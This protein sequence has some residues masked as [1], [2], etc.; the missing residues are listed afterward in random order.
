MGI[1]NKDIVLGQEVRIRWPHLL[2]FPLAWVTGILSLQM[3]GT[4]LPDSFAFLSSCG[5]ALLGTILIWLFFLRGLDRSI[6]LP[7]ILSLFILKAIFVYYIWT[8]NV[9][10]PMGGGNLKVAQLPYF[11]ETLFFWAQMNK[12]VQYW[13][14]N[15]FT[16]FLPFRHV[17]YEHPEA[18]CLV[19]MPFAALPTYSEVL[20][21][22]NMFYTTVAGAAIYAIGTLEGFSRRICKLAFYL[23]L[24]Q[25]FGWYVWAPLKRDTQCQMCFG[26]FVLA[27]LLCRKRITLLILVSVL[28]CYVL[29]LYRTVYGPILICTAIYAYIS[30]DGRV[31]EKVVR[32]FFVVFIT[33]TLLFCLTPR[34]Y[35]DRVVN[36]VKHLITFYGVGNAEVAR[37]KGYQPRLMRHDSWIAS[38]PDRVVFGLVSPFPWI[39]VPNSKNAFEYSAAV[40]D[41][42][43]TALMFVCFAAIA[44]FGLHDLMKG[45]FPPV[46]I[47]FAMGIALSGFFGYAIHNVY[48]QIGMLYTFPYVLNKLRKKKMFSC[49]LISICFFV[50]SSVFWNYIK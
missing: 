1:G 26:F 38:V 16:I 23:V 31:S 8:K 28:G 36:K 20:I 33:L 4:I 21:P 30:A 13:T 7:L 9:F 2:V 37:E 29:S 15:G 34:Q 50:I 3:F 48:V 47:V 24:L 6:S 45:K 18:M 17:N 40:A 27:V 10:A 25:P 44:V 49:F 32:R 11:R 41:D 46:S 39:N 43:H 19:A 5:G 42:L 22:W 14:T 12:L 35:S